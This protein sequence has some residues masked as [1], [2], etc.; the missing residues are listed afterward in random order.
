MSGAAGGRDGRRALLALLQAS[1]AAGAARCKAAPTIARAL[2]CARRARPRTPLDSAHKCLLQ[3]A[4]DSVL[5]HKQFA[6]AGFCSLREREA[7]A[8]GGRAAS[9]LLSCGRAGGEQGRRP[10]GAGAGAAAMRCFEPT[11]ASAVIRHS[12]AVGRRAAGRV[13][14]TDCSQVEEGCQGLGAW[15]AGVMQ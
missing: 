13:L 2:T 3:A 10:S 12:R 6:A 7:K 14:L 11:D 15:L 1:L 8:G 9:L 4:H 5:I